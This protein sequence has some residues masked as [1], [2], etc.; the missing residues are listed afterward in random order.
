MQSVDI[1]VIA[2]FRIIVKTIILVETLWILHI[3]Q[4]KIKLCKLWLNTF[5]SKFVS[6]LSIRLVQTL[7]N[8][9]TWI[10]NL[11][12]NSLIHKSTRYGFRK[13]DALIAQLKFSTN[14]A[15]PD[16]LEVQRSLVFLTCCDVTW[17]MTCNSSSQNHIPGSCPTSDPM[18]YRSSPCTS[19]CLPSAPT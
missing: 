4:I 5:R 14:I 8:S 11:K 7:T 6:K 17:S 1:S 19:P 13:L 16:V 9:T 10:I 2:Q 3:N 15:T 18:P 12:L